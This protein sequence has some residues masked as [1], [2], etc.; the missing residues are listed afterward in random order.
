M[1][2]TLHEEH[3]LKLQVEDKLLQLKKEFFMLD[4]DHKQ[5][6]QKLDELQAQK[7]KLSE[8]VMD[9]TLRLEQEIQKR[10]LSQTDL[11][12]QKQQVSV[13]AS[14]EKQLKQELNQLLDMK[15][16][17]EKQNQELSRSYCHAFQNEPNLQQPSVLPL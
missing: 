2:S 5:A 17:L 14:S 16:S 10:S 11:K 8:E 6:Q 15:Q 12:A 1:E 9:L 7:E 13:L 3:S 4:C